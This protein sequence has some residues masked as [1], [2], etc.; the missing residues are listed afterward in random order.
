MSSYLIERRQFAASTS[1]DR[2][3]GLDRCHAFLEAARITELEV[4]LEVVDELAELEAMRLVPA[5]LEV[6]L[7]LTYASLEDPWFE[8]PEDQLPVAT[9]DDVLPLERPRRFHYAVGLG[10]LAAIVLISLVI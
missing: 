3:I 8:V 5:E 7:E 10:L 4:K 1:S 2:P 9:D 6:E